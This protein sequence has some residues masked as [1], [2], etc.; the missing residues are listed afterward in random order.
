MP[1]TRTPAS[2]WRRGSRPPPGRGGGPPG[3]RGGGAAGGAGAAAAGSAGGVRVQRLARAGFRN[4]SAAYGLKQWDVQGLEYLVARPPRVL[5]SVGAAE[6][7]GDRLAHHPA[8]RRLAARIAIEPYP[9]RLMN[10]GGPAI[11]EAMARL[12]A[13]RR[14]LPS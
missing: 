2:R 12:T 3:A 5:F 8:L 10:C 13:A 6:A 11:V 4:M 14:R 9:V 1:A 7:G